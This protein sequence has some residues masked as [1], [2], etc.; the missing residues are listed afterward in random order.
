MLI[1]CT[2]VPIIHVSGLIFFCLKHFA[3][4]YNL[5]V[6]HK[7]EC[8]SVGRMIGR[9]TLMCGFGCC[10]YL[11]LMFLSFM[12]NKEFLNGLLCLLLLFLSIL[13]T[14]RL[15]NPLLDDIDLS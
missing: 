8:A 11:S 12:L 1:F 13:L 2:T 4:A 9:I 6:A 5:L 10:I 7:F 3:D 14:C 15:S